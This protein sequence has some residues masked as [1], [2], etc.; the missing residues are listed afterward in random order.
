MFYI[1]LNGASH[2]I[3]DAKQDTSFSTQNAVANSTIVYFRATVKL[4]GEKTLYISAHNHL[5]NKKKNKT[6]TKN[7]KRKECNERQRE[8]MNSRCKQ[9]NLDILSTVTF[10]GIDMMNNDDDDDYD[11]YYS[12]MNIIHN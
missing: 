8:Y 5:Y 9:Y 11:N 3:D 4:F 6:A 7:K 1:A 2:F 10:Q 12:T